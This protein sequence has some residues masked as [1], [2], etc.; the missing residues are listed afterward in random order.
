MVEAAK[1]KWRASQ[2]EATGLA[3]GRDYPR[4]TGR[5]G[6]EQPSFRA[7]PQP[8][9]PDG[10]PSVGAAGEGRAGRRR[11]GDV[12]GGEVY[13][14]GVYGQ[15]LA[16]DPPPSAR[17]VV[18]AAKATWHAQQD[19]TWR[20]PGDPSE[21]FRDPAALRGAGPSSRRPPQPSA[22]PPQPQPLVTPEPLAPRGASWATPAGR[23]GGGGREDGSR[24]APPSL[25]A[26]AV[27]AARWLAMQVAPSP[28]QER[29]RDERRETPNRRRRRQQRVADGAADGR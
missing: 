1:S 14:E 19:G 3:G 7:Q 27:K 15:A 2:D 10:R 17:A 9:P 29:A 16:R 4:Y 28:R 25:Q 11:G 5:R 21:A 12:Y 8:P 6:R 20:P 18:E 23:G 13:G 22:P 26:E 24:P